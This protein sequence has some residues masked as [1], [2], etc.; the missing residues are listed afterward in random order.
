[1]IGALPTTLEISGKQY[2]IRS[3]FRV[4]LSIFEAFEDPEFSEREKI[5]VTLRSLYI[6]I[7]PREYIS[8]AFEKAVWFM[9]GGD[10]P[11]TKKAKEKVFDWKYDESILFP[12][13]NKVAGY[14][15]R[16]CRYLHWWSFIGMFNE[17]GEGLFSTVMNIR[18]KRAEGKKMDKWEVEFY[19]SHKNMINIQTAADKAEIEE[20]EAFL[21]ELLGE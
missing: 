19:N 1:M 10:I 11:K 21:K 18:N 2:A 17:I 4:V 5:I 16:S 14:E 9:D 3:D 20:T 6:D 15:T 13:V 7:I 12:A 8:E